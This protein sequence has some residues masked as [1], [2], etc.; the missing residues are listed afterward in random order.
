MLVQWLYML[1]VAENTRTD[2]EH[3]RAMLK[4]V[5]GIN[6]SARDTLCVITRF[7]TC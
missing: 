6:S 4:G 1:S 2:A 3:F 7:G 5:L